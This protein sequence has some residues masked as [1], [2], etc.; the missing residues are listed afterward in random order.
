MSEQTFVLASANKDKAAEIAAILGS[1]PGLRLYP[2][3]ADVPDVEENGATLVENARLK[4][5][6][7][8]EATGM[9]A[10]SDD[11]GLEI[12]ALGGAPGVYSARYSGEHATY[13]D[14]VTKV[15]AELDRVGATSPAQRAATFRSVAFVAYPDG[16][17]VW[18]EGAV[19]GVIA[20]RPVGDAGFGYDPVFVPDDC[21]GRTFAQMEAE[22]K[23]RVS[24]R[25][26]AFR[27]LAELLGADPGSS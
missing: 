9:A 12:D 24:H 20:P 6:A 2:R 7:L 1:V 14:N 16:G 3:P 18:A 11:T 22:E 13:A 23:H 21:G 5:V 17:E 8:M 27:A 25:G 10:V 19:A 4:A 15:L 26:R